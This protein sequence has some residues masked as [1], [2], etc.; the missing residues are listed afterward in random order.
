MTDDQRVFGDGSATSRSRVCTFHYLVGSSQQKQPQ[1]LESQQQQQQ[2]PQ[3]QHSD[4]L[5]MPS[6]RDMPSFEEWKRRRANRPFG[7]E[8]VLLEL[9]PKEE[10]ARKKQRDQR[11]MSLMQP[12][13]QERF[14]TYLDHYDR[15]Q[16][17][18]E[19]DR[20]ER[21]RAKA[22]AAREASAKAAARKKEQHKLHKRLDKVDLATDSQFVADVAKS[23]YYRLVQREQ[24]Q[25]FRSRDDHDQFWLGELQTK[26]LLRPTE[27]SALGRRQRRHMTGAAGAGSGAHSAAGDDL[28]QADDQ[29]LHP[30]LHWE[31]TDDTLQLGASRNAAGARSGGGFHSMSRAQQNRMLEELFPRAERPKL[32]SFNVDFTKKEEKSADELELERL[33]ERRRKRLDEWREHRHM[34]QMAVTFGVATRR[35]LDERPVRDSADRLMDEAEADLGQLFGGALERARRREQL[36]LE[37]RRGGDGELDLTD[38][39]LLQSWRRNPAGERRRKQLRGVD[40]SSSTS[41]FSS[42]QRPGE[43]PLTTPATETYNDDDD[44][45][46]AGYHDRRRTQ[47]PMLSLADAHKELP[48][49]EVKGQSTLWNNYMGAGNVRFAPLDDDAWYREATTAAVTS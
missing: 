27:T 13:E 12:E 25:Q 32:S 33:K 4:A 9:D 45:D 3:Q 11:L 5:R 40:G 14:Y 41:T 24:K 38:P 22:E 7:Q 44:Y 6:N 20:E 48:H 19:R 18:V 29:E 30:T 2:Q 34:Q 16:A 26:G 17:K 39:R 10:L 21:E 31:R 28:L 1:Q 37:S 36:E 35:I 46:E 49:I 23:K 42:A 8:V 43:R 15:L 47:R